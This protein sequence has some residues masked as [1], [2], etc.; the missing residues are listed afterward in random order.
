MA[1]TRA[2]LILAIAKAHR[3]LVVNNGALNIVAFSLLEAGGDALGPQ[4]GIEYNNAMM[5]E[6]EA[7]LE[8]E[9]EDQ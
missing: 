7:L 1:A 8:Q 2:E 9:T 4:A 6:L 5:K 3:A